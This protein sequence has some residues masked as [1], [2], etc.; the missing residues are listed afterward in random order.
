MDPARI[1]RQDAFVARVGRKFSNGNRDMAG[2]IAMLTPP[3]PVGECDDFTSS[4]SMSNITPFPWPIPA[5][6]GVNLNAP[7]VGGVAGSSPA[8]ADAFA[9]LS[10]GWAWANTGGGS[11]YPWGETQLRASRLIPPWVCTPVPGAPGLADGS[12]SDLATAMTWA[13][14]LAIGLGAA[15]ILA[16]AR[17]GR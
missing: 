4:L 14:Y 2:V 3:P 15:F 16:A 9:K 13:K 7:S 8:P 10:R 1:A 6:A 11:S 17:R 12:P 5:A